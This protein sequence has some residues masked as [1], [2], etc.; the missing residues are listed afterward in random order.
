MALL[1]VQLGGGAGQQHAEDGAEVLVHFLPRD[2]EGLTLLLVQL[3]DH[4]ARGKAHNI[5]TGYP[6]WL[7]LL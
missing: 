2:L 5:S 6:A 3:G 4:L 7:L 1:G